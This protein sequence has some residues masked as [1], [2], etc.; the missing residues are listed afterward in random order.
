MGPVDLIAGPSGYGLPLVTASDLTP[1][2]LRLAYLSAPGE[3]GGLGGLGALAR[4]LAASRLPILWTPGV[5]HLPTVPP[6]RKVNRVDLG[7]ADK[8]CATALAIAEEAARRQVPELEVSLILIELGGAFTAGVAVEGGRIVDGIGGTTGPIGLRSAG[9]LDG[10]VAFLAGRI[11]KALLF[12][13]GV[14]RVR[15]DGDN[16]DVPA[17][18]T[19][20]T[21]EQGRIAWEAY[22]E[23]IDKTVAALCVAA[24]R[25]DAIIVSG[26]VARVA[27]VVETIAERTHTRAPVR[28]LTGFARVA[29]EGAQGAALIADGLAGGRY[30]ALV[31]ALALQQSG[32]TVLDHLYVIDPAVARA[33]IGIA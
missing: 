19:R 29:K 30:A 32:G 10:E 18:L 3:P 13:G 12:T 25:P 33:R 8:V 6:H 17:D 28:P 31:D 11:E 7:T 16:V 21:T 27:G 23:G 26:R 1:D 24:P 9:A 4:A 22:L 15:G 14:M 5:M 2:D 20:P